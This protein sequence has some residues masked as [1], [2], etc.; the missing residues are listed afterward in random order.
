MPPVQNDSTCFQFLSWKKC[1]TKLSKDKNCWINLVPLKFTFTH[2]LWECD[3]RQCDSVPNISHHTVSECP[4]IRWFA[5][6]TTKVLLNFTVRFKWT[7]NPLIFIRSSSLPVWCFC[8]KA[9]T[10]WSPIFQLKSIFISEL[11]LFPWLSRSPRNLGSQHTSSV[12]FRVFLLLPNLSFRVQPGSELFL[13]SS[14]RT[15]SLEPAPP[16]S[17]RTWSRTPSTPWPS[18]PSTTRWRENHS[19][20]TGKRVSSDV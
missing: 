8:S 13:Y 2:N 16:P 12:M 10:F 15:R 17:W 1:S 18:C 6:E 19:L 7:K 9:K 4:E 14:T 11:R 3:V 5:F 20:K